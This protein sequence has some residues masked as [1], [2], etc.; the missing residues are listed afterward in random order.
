MD[1]KTKKRVR[2][3]L[4]FVVKP[5]S[6]LNRAKPSGICNQDGASKS[7]SAEASCV[8]NAHTVNARKNVEEV[9]F[10]HD[11]LCKKLSLFANKEMFTRRDLVTLADIIAVYTELNDVEVNLARVYKVYLEILGKPEVEVEA[12]SDPLKPSVIDNLLINSGTVI[13]KS[14][15]KFKLMKEQHPDSQQV[16]TYLD[17]VVPNP[18]LS[19]APSAHS[20]Q[21]SKSKS[22]SSGH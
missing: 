19:K 21:K 1:H 9:L 22:G 8:E 10:T 5:K 15:S 16:I 3:N 14:L 6:K 17:F 18:Q 12:S 13:S 7:N 4:G 2:K 11:S 20:S